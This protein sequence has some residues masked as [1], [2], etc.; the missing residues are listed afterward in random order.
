MQKTRRLM[1]EIILNPVVFY[2]T[3]FRKPNFYVQVMSKHYS[4]VYFS[5]FFFFFFFLG[6]GGREHAQKVKKKTA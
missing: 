3:W 4:D 2:Y 5:F 6:G 1:D